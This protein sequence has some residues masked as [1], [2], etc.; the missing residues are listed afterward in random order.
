MLAAAVLADLRAFAAPR[1][2]TSTVTT[3]SLP[4]APARR[5]FVDCVCTAMKYFVALSC[6]V[7]IESEQGCR[8]YR[9]GESIAGVRNNAKCLTV[10][11]PGSGPHTHGVEA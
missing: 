10:E 11:P 3:L 9:E 2:P 7:E 6:S 4:D 5:A 1:K 8:I